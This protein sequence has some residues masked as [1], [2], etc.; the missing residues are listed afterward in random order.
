MWVTHDA[1]TVELTDFLHLPSMPL[2]QAA[3]MDP[4][5]LREQTSYEN[6]F[7]NLHWLV[8]NFNEY[9]DVFDL[10]KLDLEAW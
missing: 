4:D 5:G 3:E 7:D 2:A 10:P 8:A 1:R 9:L 6:L